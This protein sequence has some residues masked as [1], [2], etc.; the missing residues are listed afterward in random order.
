MS[1]WGGADMD[2]IFF[3]HCRFHYIIFSLKLTPLLNFLITR[4]VPPSFPSPGFAASVPSSAPYF[5]SHHIPSQS[6]DLISTSTTSFA[7]SP[8]TQPSLLVRLSLPFAWTVAIVSPFSRIGNLILSW[9]PS[10]VNC[11]DSLWTL[12]KSINSSLPY[13]FIMSILWKLCNVYY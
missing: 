13:C 4:S 1:H 5:P 7:F 2:E 3:L 11:S 6:S 9:W 10:A 12:E 8:F